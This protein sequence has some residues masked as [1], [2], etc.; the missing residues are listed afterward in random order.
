MSVVRKINN[1]FAYSVGDRTLTLVLLT[2]IVLLHEYSIKEVTLDLICELNF[3]LDRLF[4]ISLFFCR[5]Q[6]RAMS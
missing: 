6:Y 1:G 4:G 5:H 2:D 3:K